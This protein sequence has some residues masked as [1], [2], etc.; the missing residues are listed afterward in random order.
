MCYYLNDSEDTSGK[1]YVYQSM[2]LQFEKGRR[3]EK[4]LTDKE[5]EYQHFSLVLSYLEL[6]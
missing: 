2:S 1:L 5:Q 3:I 4:A 6:T